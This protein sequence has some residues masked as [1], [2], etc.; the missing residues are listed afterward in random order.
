MSRKRVIIGQSQWAIA[1]QD[2]ESVIGQIRSA[3]ENGTAAELPL[4]DT[5]GRS[6]TVYLNGKVVET[7]VVD[8]DSDS[9]PGEIS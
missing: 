9:R 1:D 2:V 6:V 3:M 8:L 7:V 4:L 5:S